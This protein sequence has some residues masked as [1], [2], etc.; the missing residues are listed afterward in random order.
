M[1]PLVWIVVVGVNGAIILFG[2]W[3]SRETTSAAEALPVIR[4]PGTIRESGSNPVSPSPP[5]TLSQR[6]E[7]PYT[8]SSALKHFPLSATLCL[9]P[10]VW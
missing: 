9:W 10:A 1:S 7:I 4:H 5:D 6:E 3:K 2:I 8:T